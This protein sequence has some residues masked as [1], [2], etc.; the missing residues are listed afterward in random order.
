MNLELI[1]TVALFLLLFGFISKRIQKT[2]LTSTM[3]FVLFGIL[4]SKQFL[5]ILDTGLDS[6]VIHVIAELTLILVLFT[7]ASRIDLTQL[8]REH[9]IP[10]RLLGIGLP[11]TIVFGAIA[12]FVVFNFLTFWDLPKLASSRIKLPIPL[13]HRECITS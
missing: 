5:G 7:D 13:R 6:S 9:A 8:I 11:L 10:V 2:P 12:A 1:A 4:I 3:V